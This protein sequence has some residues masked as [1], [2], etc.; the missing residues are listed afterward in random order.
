M[1]CLGSQRKM[2]H[3]DRDN[4]QAHWVLERPWFLQ[5]GGRGLGSPSL[6]SPP[7]LL[8]PAT[9]SRG[10]VA[11]L[12]RHQGSA[13]LREPDVTGIL[14]LMLEKPLNFPLKTIPVQWGAVKLL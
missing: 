12:G 8:S 3:P 1:L 13:G 6:S 11:L 10:H 5:G 2:W 4:G 9:G 14:P 7:G